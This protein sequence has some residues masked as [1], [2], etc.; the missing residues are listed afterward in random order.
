MGTFPTSPPLTIRGVGSKTGNG[1]EG[2][3]RER[4][5]ESKAESKNTNKFL[6]RGGGIVRGKHVGRF[7]GK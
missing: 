5:W 7:F 1:R 6:G 4:S 3:E 2:C